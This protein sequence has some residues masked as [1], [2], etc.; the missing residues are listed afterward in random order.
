[1]VEL[2]DAHAVSFV[3]VTQQFNT[4]TSMGRLTLNVLLSFAQFEREVTGER[5]RDK[6]KASKQRGIWMGGHVPLGYDHVE[7]KLIINEEE[8]ALVRRIYQRYLDLGCVRLLKQELD[9]NNIRTKARKEGKGGKPFHPGHLYQMLQNPLYIGKIRHKDAVHDGL[10][11]PIIDHTLWEQVQAQRKA[12]T[13]GTRGNQK[14]AISILKGKLFDADCSKLI[15]SHANKRG[16]RYRYYVSHHLIKGPKDQAKRGWRLPAVELERSVRHLLQ[17][18]LQDRIRLAHVMQE[19]GLPLHHVPELLKAAQHAAE[20]LKTEDSMRTLLPEL[21][22]RI[23]IQDQGLQVSISL[24]G[25]PMLSHELALLVKA[26]RITQDLPMQL[27]RR[28]NELRV[29]VS[30][31]QCQ[32]IDPVLIK[33]ITRAH[34]WWNQLSSGEAR[35]VTELA[36]RE[37]ITDRYISKHLPLAFLSPKITQAI[38]AGRQPAQL[39]AE[40]LIECA[41]RHLCWEDQQRDLSIQ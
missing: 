13:Q 39:S 11:D 14:T 32:R 28:R 6:I 24:V 10:H 29:V 38:M 7:R 31:G 25:L 18:T 19:A 4:T 33:A 15:P 5:I 9:E 36:T 30:G 21:I 27:L 20:A 16:V 37:G 34:H 23:I 8:A 17:D 3:A 2:F 40:Q 1:M 41:T 12:H 35:S 22:E 26:I